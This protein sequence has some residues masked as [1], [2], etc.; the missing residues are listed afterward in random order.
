MVR[1][2]VLPASWSLGLIVTAGI[3][4]GVSL[5]VAGFILAVVA[6]AVMQ[7]ILSLPLVKL[8]RWYVPLFL[9]STGLASTV[10]ALI[11]ASILVPG[12]TI[13]GMRSWLATTLV[14]WLVTTIGAITLP[15]VVTREGDGSNR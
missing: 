14:V 6:F 9:G 2:A 15:E 1:A 12:F 3:V 11:L 7:A 4:P 8:P 10:V 13:G 5:S